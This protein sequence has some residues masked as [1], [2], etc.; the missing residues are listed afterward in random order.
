MANF[1]YTDFK[2]GL[3]VAEFNLNATD[4]IRYVY[5]MSNTTF[6]TEEDI[7][8]LGGATTPDYYDGTNHDSTNGQALAGEV[9]AAD[10]VNDR[11]EFDATDNTITALGAGT[12]QAVLA[13]VFKWVT[14]IGLSR[15]MAQIDT[16]GFPF[17]GNGGDVTIQWNAEGIIQTT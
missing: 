11:G 16:G 17:D 14:N 7:T 12:R 15:P 3:M 10:N 8:T 5:A 13:L 6:D 2:R 4:D 9:V 1:G